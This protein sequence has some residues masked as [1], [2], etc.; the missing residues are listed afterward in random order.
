MRQ[1]TSPNQRRAHSANFHQLST[2]VPFSS[3]MCGGGTTPAARGTDA[4]APQH[5]K[6]CRQEF[7]RNTKGEV[8]GFRWPGVEAPAGKGEEQEEEHAHDDHERGRDHEAEQEHEL[9][10]P[11][12]PQLGVEQRFLGV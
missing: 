9:G 10:A 6:E 2:N 3:S 12:A 4:R 11:L 1:P 8:G 5:A 7:E